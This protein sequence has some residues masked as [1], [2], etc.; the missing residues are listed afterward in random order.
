MFID[1]AKVSM[2][3]GKGGNGVVAW[4][5][6]KYE[7]AGGPYGGDGGNGGSIVLRADEGI[8]TLMDYRYK[9]SYVGESGEDGRTKKQYG[10][11]GVDI[12]LKLPVGTIVK[13]EETGKVIVD[14]KEAGQ[15]FIIARGGKGGRGNAKFATSTRQ[16]PGFAE[17]G[18]KGQERNIILELKLLADVGLVGFPNVG[19]STLLSIVSAAKPKIANY[20]FTTL[21]PNLG[22]VKVAE[23]KSFVIADIPGLIEGA[24]KGAGLGHEFLRHI[25]RTRILVHVLDVSGSE[26]RN[27][28]DDFYKIN[29]EIFD[30]NDKLKLR[31][32]IIAANKIDIP[33]SDEWLQKV[34]DEFEVQGIQVFPISAATNEGIKELFF[35]VWDLLQNT[36]VNYDSFDDEY[37][38][39]ETSKEDQIIVKKEDNMFIVEGDFMER[40]LESTYI[41]NEESLRYFQEMLKIKGVIDQLRDLGISEGESVFICGY[42]FE[43]FN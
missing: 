1:V 23:E 5:K 38:V 26:G 11:A 42:E 43:F 29:Q 24:S 36:E 17:A 20:H 18:T 7:P 6:E 10:K 28:I 9:R 37:F 32:Q 14:L 40:L 33:S 15:E 8:R 27:P 31:P 4:R 13:D 12:T 30:Y 22:V 16:A 21:R 35:A 25:E 41:D 34:K 3:A 19:K 2:K 39:E